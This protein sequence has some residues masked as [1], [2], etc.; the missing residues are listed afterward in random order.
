MK[1]LKI[2]G[3]WNDADYV[4]RF[5]PISDETITMITPV[6]EAIKEFNADTANKWD[7]HN[8]DTNTRGRGHKTPKELYV[9]TGKITQEA[10]EVFD[11]LLPSGYESCIYHVASVEIL[12]ITNIDKLL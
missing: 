10:Y 4:Y 6:V 12:E 8:W 9:D 3:D 5:Q 1:Y 11:G 2:K 7:R